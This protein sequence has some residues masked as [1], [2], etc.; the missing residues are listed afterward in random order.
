MQDETAM[1]AAATKLDQIVGDFADLEPRERL[2]LLLEFAEGL[3]PL[4]SRYQAEKDRGEHR[5]HECQTPVFLWVEVN[6]GVVQVYGDVAPEAPTVKGFV[7]ILADAFS[8]ASPEEV[9]SVQPDLLQ[10]LGLVQALGMM[11]MRGLQAIQYTI[12]DQVRK[13]AAPE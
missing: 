11:R 8:G 4:P 3:P 5:V 12:L 1:S 10:R 13:A 2:E 7:G 9:L 6:D